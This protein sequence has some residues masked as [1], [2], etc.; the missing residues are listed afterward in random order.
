MLD[1]TISKISSW[2]SNLLDEGQ[3]LNVELWKIK[4]KL[5]ESLIVLAGIHVLCFPDSIV[6]VA[7]LSK[8]GV[9]G[10]A[11]TDNIRL[12]KRL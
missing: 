8:W 7:I 6:V 9:L 10:Q 12:L 11:G 4:S 1:I 5:V 2:L 3:V